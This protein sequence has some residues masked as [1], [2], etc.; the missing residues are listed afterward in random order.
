MSATSRA[1]IRFGSTVLIVGFLATVTLIGYQR[2]RGGG[3]DVGSVDPDEVGLDPTDIAVGLYRGFQHTEYVMG[4]P[5]FILNSIRTL[6]RAS[7]W[8][9][10][11]GVRLQ[12][13]RDGEEGPV[14]TAESASYNIETREARL[15]GGIHV[16]FPSGAFLNTDSGSFDSRRQVFESDAPVL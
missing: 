5:A 3:S 12:L 14:V 10:I 13:F 11:E 9:E 2:T 6:S 1:W 4:Q 7:G 8:Q 16:E 15:D